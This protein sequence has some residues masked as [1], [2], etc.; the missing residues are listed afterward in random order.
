[1]TDI[2]ITFAALSDVGLTRS[3]NEDAYLLTDLSTGVRF[4]ASA[5]SGQFKLGPRGAL[6]TLSDGM[7]GHAAGEV[8]SSTVISSVS[9][10]LQADAQAP[11]EQ[12]LEA[13][14]RRANAD[15]IE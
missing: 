10:T 14:V 7:G 5:S 1:M 8:A 15:V 12:R 6:L 9:A 2:I 3:V 11:A 4:D 13:A